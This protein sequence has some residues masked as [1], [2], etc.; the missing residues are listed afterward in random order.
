M[1]T[2]LSQR[3]PYFC[4]A[5]KWVAVETYSGEK[6]KEAVEASVV[7]LTPSGAI[8]TNPSSCGEALVEPTTAKLLEETR[9]TPFPG[10]A[11]ST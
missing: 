11:K 10:C 5:V 2:L 1:C 8:E 3:G 6:T 9:Y 7:L 4:G